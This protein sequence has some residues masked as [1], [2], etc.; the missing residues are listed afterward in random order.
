MKSATCFK[1]DSNSNI[2]IK[3]Y[4]IL[5]KL[6]LSF[7]IMAL[8][9]TG[10]GTAFCETNDGCKD[11][12][13]DNSS[14]YSSSFLNSIFNESSGLTKFF[15]TA[16]EI[17]EANLVQPR[18][19]KPIY[20]VKWIDRN[21][22][23]VCFTFDDGYSR[24]SIETVLNVLKKEKIKCTF[25]IVGTC[26]RLYPDLWKRAVNEGHHICNHTNT[27][28]FLASLSDEQI[29]KEITGWESAATD[30]LGKDYVEDMKNNFPYFRLPGGEGDSQKRIMKV[31]ADCKYIPVGW[32]LETV[33]SVLNHHN[34][35][36]ES[37]GPIAEEVSGYVSKNS[38]KGMI[39]LM[40]F[41]AYDSLE[42]ENTIDNILKKGLVIK[43]ISEFIK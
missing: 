37:A 22:Q 30:V 27:H 12:T 42:L 4:G 11:S 21:S 25:F 17:A 16:K 36:K 7:M 8:T 10:M 39:I 31:I 3:R 43:D 2:P 29:K 38:S 5:K 13:E 34:L 33:S 40:H 26:L 1:T 24:Q 32:S 6:F 23:S 20:P 19:F 28:T 14:D 9:I 41:N 18:E 15:K 35:K